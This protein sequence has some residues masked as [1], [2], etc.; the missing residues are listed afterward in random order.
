MATL[1]AFVGFRFSH[2]EKSCS[3][4][5]TIQGKQ[6]AYVPWMNRAATPRAGGGAET[7]RAMRPVAAAP[8]KQR[9]TQ[10]GTWGS[11][12]PP[13]SWEVELHSNL[14]WIRLAKSASN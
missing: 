9:Q 12:K 3:I 5:S 8:P 13:D 10:R 6:G 14:R 2:N 4:S 7:P 11:V 1:Y